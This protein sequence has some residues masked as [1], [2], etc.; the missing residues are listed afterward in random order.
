M[1]YP[2][3]EHISVFLSHLGQFRGLLEWCAKAIE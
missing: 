3:E 1:R 2:S